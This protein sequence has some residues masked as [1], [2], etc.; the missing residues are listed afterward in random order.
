[1]LSTAWLEGRT[2]KVFKFN[3][4]GDG[5]DNHHLKVPDDAT[6]SAAAES[7]MKVHMRHFM[8]SV[9]AFLKPI[10]KMFFQSLIES[11]MGEFNHSM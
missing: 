2:K 10:T 4:G 3:G 8:Q 6:D 1:M 5:F 7:T 11:V 9:F